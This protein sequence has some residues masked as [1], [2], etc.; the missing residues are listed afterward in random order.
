VRGTTAQVC[1]IP[2]SMTILD[3]LLPVSIVMAE[4]KLT[5]VF[6]FTNPGAISHNE[7][8]DL[9]KEVRCALHVAGGCFAHCGVGCS[10]C[11]VG[12]SG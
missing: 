1:N 11:C 2:N 8:L 4:R 6:N 9:Y 3:D 5:G 10:H 12:C 7:I